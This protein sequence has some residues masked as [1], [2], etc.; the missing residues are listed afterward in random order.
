M[1]TDSKRTHVERLAALR[2]AFGRRKELA[3]NSGKKHDVSIAKICAEAKVDKIYVYGHR[4]ADDDPI[5]KKY[6]ALR[7]EI[8]AFQEKLAVGQEITEDRRRLKVLQDKYDA[9]LSG[10]EP[11][12]R[13]LAYFKAQSSNDSGQLDHKRDQITELLARIYDLESQLAATPITGKG[14]V[15]AARL[16][17][18][19]VSPDAYRM[20]GGKYRMSSRKQ[21]EEAWGKAYKTLEELLSRNLK[22]RLYILVGLPCSGKTTWAEEGEVATDRHPVIWDATNLT[23]MDRY[24]LVVSLS[25]YQDLPKTCVYFDTD[26]E[27]IRE[28]NCTQRS[29]DKRMSDDELSLMRDKLE[30]P[31]PYEEIWINE[32]M[33]VRQNHV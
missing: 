9:L 30:K 18:H 1:T 14:G 29:P 24:R 7:D 13:D 33:I 3:R 20:I 6:L 31:D 19:V 16:Q 28:R 25:R 2:E 21:E 27:V 11:L 8:L 17:K 12:Q 5:R 10:V 32:L 23:S 26:M 15:L 4:L 22:M